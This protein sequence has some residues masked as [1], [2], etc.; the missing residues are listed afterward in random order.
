MY[1]HSSNLIYGGVAMLVNMSLVPTLL[2]VGQVVE[3]C[4]I[5]SF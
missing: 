3:V 1:P 2:T 5:I 4:G